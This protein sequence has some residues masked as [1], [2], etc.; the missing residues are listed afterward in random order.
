MLCEHDSWACLRA[1]CKCSKYMDKEPRNIK[2]KMS[3]RYGIKGG[4]KEEGDVIHGKKKITVQKKKR[5]K[6]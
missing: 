6:K 3:V 1:T 2:V 4:E 5:E